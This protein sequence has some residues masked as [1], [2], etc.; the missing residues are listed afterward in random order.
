MKLS[1]RL[2]W[3]T[4]TDIPF[5]ELR[6]WPVDLVTME[7]TSTGAGLVSVI[8]AVGGV[9][10]GGVGIG[11]RV[12]GRGEGEGT[13]G[14]SPVVTCDGENTKLCCWHLFWSFKA[15]KID[16]MH[17]IKFLKCAPLVSSPLSWIGCT[18][19]RPATSSSPPSSPP[20]RRRGSAVGPAWCWTAAQRVFACRTEIVWWGRAALSRP[21]WLQPPSGRTE[22]RWR[23]DGEK[24]EK[25]ER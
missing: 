15:F 2:T 22:G 13:E 19:V 20:V 23:L 3:H 4:N 18:A 1:R 17:K 25:G 5:D 21:G 8:T 14:N 9:K 24:G 6:L 7:T 10:D 12:R 11:G 16:H